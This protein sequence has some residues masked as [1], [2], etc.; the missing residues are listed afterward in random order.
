MAHGTRHTGIYVVVV[1]SGEPSSHPGTRRVNFPLKYSV[2]VVLMA[3]YSSG[4]S[5]TGG[6]R[7]SFSQITDHCD[8]KPTASF[9]LW[10]G[11]YS[12]RRKL[13][14]NQESGNQIPGIDHKSS[15]SFQLSGVNCFLISADDVDLIFSMDRF[16]GGFWGATGVLR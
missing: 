1:G 16:E 4:S 11:L 3:G 10:L 8:R 13:M 5:S 14:N 6:N 15:R 12:S 9:Y 2:F 7:S